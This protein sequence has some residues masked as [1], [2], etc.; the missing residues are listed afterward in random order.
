MASAAKGPQ[1]VD[2]TKVTPQQLTQLSK[3]FESE[4]DT[5]SNSY[6]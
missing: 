6:Q 1:E 2:I 3:A 4:I 5:L